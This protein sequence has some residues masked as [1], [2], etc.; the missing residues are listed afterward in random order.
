MNAYVA[1]YEKESLIRLLVL[2]PLVETLISSYAADEK[3]DTKFLAA[4]RQ[5]RT[6][7]D[8]AIKLRRSFLDKEAD[9]K[10]VKSANKLN[11]LFLPTP[12]YKKAFKEMMDLKEN[13][14]MGVEDFNDWYSFVIETTC[15]TCTREDY[16]DCP[17]RR[18]LSSYDVCPIDPGAVGKCQ[19]SYVG[20]PEAEELQPVDAET[21]TAE[22]Y[23]QAVAES[24]ALRD[25]LIEYNRLKCELNALLHPNWSGSENLSLGD[26]VACVRGDLK[27]FQEKTRVQADEIKNLREINESME[28]A[29]KEQLAYLHKIEQ[30]RDKARELLAAAMTAQEQPKEEYPVSIGLA[31]GGEFDYVLPAHMTEIMIREIQQPRQ[32]RSTCAQYVDGSLVAIDLQGVVALHVDKLP[33][34]DWVRQKAVSD[35]PGQLEKYRVECKCG[36]EYFAEM[37]AARTKAYCR[38]CKTP[39][40]ADKK[41]EV[42][43]A[44]GAAATLLTNR[45]WVER[46][47]QA[48]PPKEIPAPQLSQSFGK[49]YK[50]PCNPFAS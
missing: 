26:L 18:V 44:D 13:F 19:Y 48:G 11:V 24:T 33:P 5:S 36:A 29:D 50:D 6:R 31:S 16:E 12:E 27:R 30:E 25:Q 20:T 46:E 42:K 22:K 34:G 2:Q 43:T 47:Q 1:K 14:P 9:D 28:K 23:N 45:Y 39:V 49:Q 7:L 37:N 41:A 38:D 3:T 40:F 32:Y 10:L 15:K 4:L 35:V 21:V 17:A 8:N